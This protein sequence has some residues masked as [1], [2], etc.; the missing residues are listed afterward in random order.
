[1]LQFASEIII[2][3][4]SKK[5]KTKKKKL[6]QDVQDTESWQNVTMLVAFTDFEVRAAP[7][8]SLLAYH[9]R[10]LDCCCKYTTQYR[11]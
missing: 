2:E 11:D 3:K 6:H 10:D 1:M 5:K 7:Y 8:I 4:K 9:T